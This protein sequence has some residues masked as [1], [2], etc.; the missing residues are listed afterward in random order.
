MSTTAFDGLAQWCIAGLAR[1]WRLTVSGNDAVANLR[2]SGHRLVFAVWHAALLV[3]L[4][5]RRT[6]GITLLVS[7][8]AD[9]E[10][11]ARAGEHWGYRIVRGSS[12]RGGVRGLK[13]IVR[14]LQLGGDV[15]TTPDGPRG[16]AR[17]AKPGLVWAA[18]REGATIIP[19][20]VHASSHW[21]L[22]S[23][24]RFRIPKVGARVH[25]HYGTPLSLQ[26]V[27][28]SDAAGLLATALNRVEDETAWK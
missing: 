3:P 5:H 19:I 24:D 2:S 17:V 6:E 11:L 12:T 23:W 21:Q 27:D 26:D 20:G 8:H 15:A 10:R 16:P 18:A 4:W 9:A 22:S 28:A 25:L 7:Q 1:T 13:G 14:A